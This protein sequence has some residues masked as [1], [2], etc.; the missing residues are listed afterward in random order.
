MVR[1]AFPPPLIVIPKVQ[2]RLM[3]VVMSLTASYTAATTL[4]GNG[5]RVS[6]VLSPAQAQKRGLK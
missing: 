6:G 1:Q 4:P 2:I 5:D 3:R